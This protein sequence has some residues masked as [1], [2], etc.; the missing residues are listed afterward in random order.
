MQF[1]RQR[2]RRN[3][4]EQLLP[5][6]NVMFLLIIFF[7]LAGQ[8]ANPDAYAIRPPRSASEAPAAAGGLLVQINAQGL[9]A[10]EGE[11][12]SPRELQSAVQDYVASHPRGS[13]RLKA[14]GQLNASRVIAVMSVL[15]EVGVERLRLLTI[16]KES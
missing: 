9:I 13:I 6:T 16:P 3:E 8:L 1:P 2:H 11:P 10:L 15:R 14:A 7:M 4:D 12:I 5:L